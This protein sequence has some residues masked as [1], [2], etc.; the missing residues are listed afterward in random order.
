MARPGLMR[1]PAGRRPRA[2]CRA[3]TRAPS[4]SPCRR[5]PRRA[6]PGHRPRRRRWPGSAT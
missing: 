6:K 4:P 3:P 1:S 2:G 5:Q